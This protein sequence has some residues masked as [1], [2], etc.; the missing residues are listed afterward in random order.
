MSGLRTL[1]AWQWA[2]NRGGFALGIAV[3]CVPA[4]AGLALLGV[5]GWYISAAAIAGATADFLNIFA[6]SAL[7]RGLAIARTAGRYGERMLTH[8]ATFRFLSDLRTRIFRGV[9]VKSLR[10][11]GAGRSAQMLNRLTS[12]LASLDTVY[13]RLVVPVVLLITAV[14]TVIGLYVIHLQAALVPLAV[15]IAILGFALVRLMR[16]ADKKMAR[17]QEA[18]LDAVR[19]RS[20]DLVA[21]RRDLAVYGGL[22]SAADRVE[23]AATRL[24]DVEAYQDRRANRFAVTISLAGQMFIAGLLLV[25]AFAAAQGHLAVPVAVGLVLMALALP[26]FLAAL[27][28]GLI[29]LPRTQLAARR[30]VPLAGAESH[31]DTMLKG[32]C[33]DLKKDAVHPCASSDET[34]VLKLERVTFAYPGARAPV[35]ND[36]SLDVGPAEVVALVGRSGCGKSTA[37]AL[38]S[39][40]LLPQGGQ[41]LFKGKRLSEMNED[42][43]RRQITVLSQRPYLFND[44][45]EANLRLA[46]PRAPQADLWRAL[47]QAALS[48]QIRARPDGLQTVLGEGG[49]GLSGG[50]RRRLG[51]A[52]ACLTTPSLWILDE[53]TEGLDEETARDVL[54]R[55]FEIRGA[56]PVLMIAHKAQ[57]IAR[58]DRIVE[59]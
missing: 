26:E 24:I 19:S 21:G 31:F 8:D 32:K 3:A 29:A 44:T 57:E 13:L 7:I 12:D 58:A 41:V 6:P 15:M 48:E 17:R 37:S 59:M 50:E 11:P 55:F 25:A 39:G 1:V 42:D 40:L 18:A 43:K 27:G 45:V 49:L 33:G 54:D 23:T 5:A 34:G 9:A 53:M 52:R 51:L 4:L 56:V 14:A 47:E 30:I 38:S 35:L 28:P 22:G 36:W 2:H 46:N 16:K 20:A 10:A